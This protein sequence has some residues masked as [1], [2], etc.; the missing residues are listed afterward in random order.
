MSVVL[1]P[2]DGSEA[3]ERALARGAE[4]ARELGLPVL[5]LQVV[6][7]ALSSDVSGLDAT[8]DDA[9]YEFARGCVDKGLEI[10]RNLGASGEGMV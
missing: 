8:S 3:S 10:L 7:T 9:E 5:V 6:P 1:V 4:A 2:I